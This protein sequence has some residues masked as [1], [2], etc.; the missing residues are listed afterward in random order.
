M[1]RAGAGLKLQDWF[2]IRTLTADGKAN[3]TVPVETC[4]ENR[5][6]KREL[7]NKPLSFQVK[8]IDS[9]HSYLESRGITRETAE[10]FGAGFFSGKGSMHGRVVIP[11]HNE[12]A[13]LVAYAGRV[14]DNSEPRY[15]LPAGFQKSLE[16][17]N[18]HRVGESDRVVAVEGFFDC[19]KVHQAGFP[20]V[21]RKNEW[22]KDLHSNERIGH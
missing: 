12:K 16:L 22:P 10:A 21:F 20:N 18:L 1:Q 7:L 3:T 15:K 5:T 9:A 19:I 13:E 6:E 14:I 8:G 4:C 17:Y 11:I 2:S